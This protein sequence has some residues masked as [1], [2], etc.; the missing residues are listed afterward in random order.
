MVEKFHILDWSVELN[1]DDGGRISKLSY[2]GNHLLCGAPE[3]FRPPMKDYGLYETRP[4]YGYDD[5]FPSVD[6]CKFPCDPEFEVPDHGELC[7]QKWAVEKKGNVIEFKTA[8]RK[9]PLKFTRRLEFSDNTLTWTFEVSSHGPTAMPFLH[10]MHP[11]MPLASVD[12]FIIPKFASVFDEVNQREISMLDGRAV[13]KYLLNQRRG[14]FSML[15]LRGI[16]DG[17]MTVNFKFPLR[18]EII[19]PDKLFPSIGIWWNNSGYPDEVGLRRCEC[20]F[21]P[22]PGNSSSLESCFRDGKYL[23]VQP[24]CVF[25]WNV[26]WVID[27][28]FDFHRN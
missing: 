13:E 6:R 27:A 20:A 28:I 3:V 8:S 1:P 18:L 17:R 11:L 12:G 14:E 5:C 9:L 19:F 23:S 2:K 25:F 24:G 26:K 15:L 16:K 22:I 4:V 10:V 7:W 21:E